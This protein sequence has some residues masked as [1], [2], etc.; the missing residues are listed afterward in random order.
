MLE[1]ID[2]IIAIE[3][4]NGWRKKKNVWLET[5]KNFENLLNKAEEE[6]DK[7]IKEIIVRVYILTLLGSRVGVRNHPS[8][9]F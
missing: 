3:K 8:K 7:F 9:K 5:I 6:T 2:K 1:Y 4:K